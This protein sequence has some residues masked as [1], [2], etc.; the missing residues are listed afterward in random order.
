MSFK[1]L[2]IAID[3][4]GKLKTNTLCI[5]IHN[6]SYLSRHVIVSMSAVWSVGTYSLSH[7]TLLTSSKLTTLCS[8]NRIV[9]RGINGLKKDTRVD[10][11]V[12][13][14][15]DYLFVGETPGSNNAVGFGYN[16]GSHNVHAFYSPS[17]GGTV[18]VGY[19]F[20]F[21][22]GSRSRKRSGNDGQPGQPGTDESNPS[23]VT[24]Q[25]GMN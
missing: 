19:T 14:N 6:I 4:W 13:S 9:N 8:I 7:T 11:P 10:I 22:G 25:P 15:G 1:F 3:L 16:S 24:G 23:S 18:G 12:G 20:R 5:Y 2:V 17:N 21:G